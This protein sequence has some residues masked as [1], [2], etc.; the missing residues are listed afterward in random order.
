MSCLSCWWQEGLLCYEG[1][2][3]RLPDGRSPKTAQKKCKQYWNKRDALT[4]CIPND[5]LIILSELRREK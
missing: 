3:K 5:K 2:F 1:E 4:T